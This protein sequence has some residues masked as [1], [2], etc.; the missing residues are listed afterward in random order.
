MT[1]A[2]A[3]LPLVTPTPCGACRVYPCIC[4]LEPVT[5]ESCLCGGEIASTSH[6]AAVAHAVR[7]H[8]DTP[9][10]EAWAIAAG[11]R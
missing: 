9:R 11:W 5:V 7:L 2:W 1:L 10:H 6:P 8:N 4:R 3:P